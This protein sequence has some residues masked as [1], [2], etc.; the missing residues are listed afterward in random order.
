MWVRSP[1]PGDTWRNAEDWLI[2]WEIDMPTTVYSY[3]RLVDIELLNVAT[4]RRWAIAEAV[5][6]DDLHGRRVRGHT[7]WHV[8]K[9]AGRYLVMVRMHHLCRDLQ[10]SSAEFTIE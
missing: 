8:D 2:R 4:N 6:S 5:P 9:P 10:A 3:Q 7:R 1:E